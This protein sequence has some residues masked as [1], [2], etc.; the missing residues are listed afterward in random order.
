MKIAIAEGAEVRLRREA[1][2]ASQLNHPH[3]CTVYDIAEENE[4]VFFAMEHLE[5]ETLRQRIKGQ[6]LPIDQIVHVALQ[7]VDAL[8]AAHLKG[9]K[10]R[11]RRV[12]MIERDH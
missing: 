10:E 4:Q 12:A 3:I 7:I 1:Q 5:G 6:P 8:E 2:H 9:I 11:A